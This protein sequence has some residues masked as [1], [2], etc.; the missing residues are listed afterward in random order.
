MAQQFDAIV[1]GAGGMGSAAAYSLSKARQRVLVLEQFEIDHAKGSSYGSSRVIRY[2]YDHPIYIE[3]LRSAYP[4]WLALAAEAGETLYIKTGGLDIGTLDLHSFRALS[5]SMDAAHLSYE[6]LTRA[7]VGRRFPQFRLDAGME[8]LYQADAGILAASK[9]V[10]AQL[11]LSGAEVR[12]RTPVLKVIPSATHV[13]VHTLTDVYQAERLILT[14]GSWTNDLLAPLGMALPLQVMPV[15]IACFQPDRPGPYE[16]GRFPVFMIQTED[17]NGH[18]GVPTHDGVGVKLSTFYGWETVSHPSA[19]DYQ[20]SADWVEQ[21][22]GFL[23][24]YLPDVNG[25]LVSTRRCLYTMTPDKHFVID[26]HP[27]Y[28]HIVFATGFSGHGF[29]FT[30]LVGRILTDLALNG[31]T[32]HNISLF[33]RSRFQPSEPEP[34]IF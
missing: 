29:K 22:R 19:V 11:R 2:A 9:C 8:A 27:D 16:V 5:A 26:R 14:A 4:L 32:P 20:P 25:A 31:E 17:A 10:Q 18:Y 23:Q 21:M 3:L 24:H 7:E 28:P 12:D 34:K 13:E 15:Q 6:R 30:P 33:R 1:L